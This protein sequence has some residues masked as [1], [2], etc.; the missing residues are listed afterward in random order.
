[1][2]SEPTWFKNRMRRLVILLALVTITASLAWS[3]P[4][5]DIKYG[6]IS[7]QID[8]ALATQIKAETIPASLEGK[9]C[10]LWPEHVAVTLVGYPAPKM[11]REDFPH[12]RVFSVKRFR[13]AVDAG[14]RA[15]AKG[16]AFPA[17]ESWTNAFDEE[18]RVLNALLKAEPKHSAVQSFLKRTRHRTDFNTGMPFL[19]MWE[20]H[21]AFISNVKYVNFRNGKGVFFLTQWDN[22]TSRIANDG[23]EYAF[24]GITIDGKYYVYA[25]FSVSTPTLPNGDEPEVAAWNEKNYLLPRQ[26]KSYQD[27][28]RRVVA[29]LEALRGDQFQPKLELFERLISSLEVQIK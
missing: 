3:I 16:G 13:E 29:R 11:H 20:A 2:A 21:Q 14:Y 10:D 15:M 7:L 25:E 18:V 28:V 27:Y 23:L 5:K 6:G 17:P 9:P 24:Q 22:E 8:D 1:M 19:P 4:P 12:L 26:S